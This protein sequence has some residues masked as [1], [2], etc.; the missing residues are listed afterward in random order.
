MKYR[1]KHNA[2]SEYKELEGREKHIDLTGKMVKFEENL[3]I[4][5]I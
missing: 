2:D 1:N 5:K 3:K 4:G